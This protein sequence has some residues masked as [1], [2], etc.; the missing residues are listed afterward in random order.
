MPFVCVWVLKLYLNLTYFENETP[1]VMLLNFTHT[2]NSLLKF[3]IFFLTVCPKNFIHWQ[4]SLSSTI[5][6]FKN[7]YSRVTSFHKSL[8]QKVM[9]NFLFN[10]LLIISHYTLP[11][12]DSISLWRWSNPS[13]DNLLSEFLL[14]ENGEVRGIAVHAFG[15]TKCLRETCFSVSVWWN[16]IC[17]WNFHIILTFD[18]W[19]RST[20]MTVG[21]LSLSSKY[22]SSNL[23]VS[24]FTYWQIP[25]CFRA[26]TGEGKKKR[27]R[28]WKPRK[29][30]LNYVFGSQQ[31]A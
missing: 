25:M 26:K 15:I 18:T 20:N 14:S 4:P 23:L 9:K 13:E 10:L 19:K 21:R 7:T 28:E 6:K 11:I 16:V 30:V 5:G 8:V 3:C 24:Y 17:R 22:M 31:H 27:E 12:L 1:W 2:K 29:D